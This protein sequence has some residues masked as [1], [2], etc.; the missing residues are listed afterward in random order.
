[1]IAGYVKFNFSKHLHNSTYSGETVLHT[2]ARLNQTECMKLLLR[3]AP[4][5]VNDESLNGKTA[6]ELAKDKGYQICVD[7]VCVIVYA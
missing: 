4:D 1:M 7:L 6:L 3:L 2:C 5:L